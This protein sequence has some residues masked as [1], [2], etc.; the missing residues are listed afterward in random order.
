MQLD[1]GAKLHVLNKV[2]KAINEGK[3]LSDI[4][5]LAID[6]KRAVKNTTESMEKNGNETRETGQKTNDNSWAT[7]W[8]LKL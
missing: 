5:S 7:Y 6:K 1:G 2:T 3:T 4:Q 8:Q